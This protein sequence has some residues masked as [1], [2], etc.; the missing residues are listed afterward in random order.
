[1]EQSADFYKDLVDNMYEGV[2][3]VDPDRNI[4]YWNHGAERITGYPSDRVM[5]KSCRDNLLNH[6]TAD[7]KMLCLDGCPLAACM[8]DG[9]PRD[10]EVF[11]HHADGQRIPVHVMAS[12]MRD[13][14]G[15]IIG[16]VET[17]QKIANSRI[18]LVELADLRKRA[19]NDELTGLR[20]R[21]YM[22]RRLQ[23]LLAEERGDTPTTGLLFIDIDVLKL[24]NDL[25]GHEIG[26]RVIKMVS[27][28]IEAN[29]R[30][31][32]VTGRWGGDEF[33]AIIEDVFTLKSLHR[34]AEKIR[35]LVEYSR[36]DLEG[37]SCSVTVSVGGTLLNKADTRETLVDRA[38]QL[39]YRMK[40]AGRNQVLVE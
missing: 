10:A 25:H 30:S 28:T 6:V 4:I 37:R 7:G 20:N 8:K 2:Y 23:G 9:E 35:T 39:M 29:L 36:L 18:N 32:D 34:I 38:D 17:F 22:E 5:G 26:D 16:A 40:K 24:V 12:P 21:A 3:F 31:S 33:I 15:E 13:E 11:L 27:S 19:N 1:M 14:K